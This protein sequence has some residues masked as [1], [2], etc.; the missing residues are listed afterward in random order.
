[1]NLKLCHQKEGAV[2]EETLATLP[3]PP[4]PLP[5]PPAAAATHSGRLCTPGSTGKG[6]ERG[7]G[8]RGE[9]GEAGVPAA[10]R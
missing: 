5:L 9:A 2:V 8:G 6:G 7:G 3:S 10:A 1:V 4:L